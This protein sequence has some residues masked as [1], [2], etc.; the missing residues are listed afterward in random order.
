MIPTKPGAFGELLNSAPQL[1]QRLSTLTERLTELM[2]DKNQQ[3]FAGI[4]TNVE[5]LSGNL[6]DRGPE[7]A[8]TLAETRLAVQKAGIAAE[9][10]GKLSAATTGLINDES[11]PLI[12]DLR[13]TLASAN[14]TIDQLD[15]TLAEAQPGVRAFSQQ[16]MPEVGLLIRDLREMS[17]SVRAVSE[18]LDQQGAGSLIGSPKLPDYKQ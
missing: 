5:K 7:I 6:A 18:K 13:K 14:K 3:S 15:K 9:E 11:K 4:L 2:N 10:I 1:L 8:A 17:R 12:G 16:T